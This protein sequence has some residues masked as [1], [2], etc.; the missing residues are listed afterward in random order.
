M[1]KKQ[2]VMEIEHLFKQDETNNLK[3]IEYI[4]EANGEEYALI[5]FRNSFYKKCITA[6]SKGAILKAITEAVYF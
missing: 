5:E 3:G 4:V 1:N 6:N 2:W